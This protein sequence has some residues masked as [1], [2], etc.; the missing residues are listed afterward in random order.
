MKQDSKFHINLKFYDI[1]FFSN[2]QEGKNCWESG[3]PK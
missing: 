2:L 1:E 3:P